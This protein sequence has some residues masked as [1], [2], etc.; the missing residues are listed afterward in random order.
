MPDMPESPKLL[1]PPQSLISGVVK[2]A[3]VSLDIGKMSAQAVISSRAVDREFEIVEPEAFSLINYRK[4]PVVFFN[5]QQLP[6]P[7]GTSESPEKSLSVMVEADRVLATCYFSQVLPE[8]ELIY[9]LVEEKTIRATSIGFMSLE[10]VRLSDE[11]SQKLGAK[12]PIY[13]HKKIDLTE[14]SWV[15]VGCNQEA[16][17][18]HLANGRIGSKQLT[19]A[20][21]KTLEP[22]RLESPAMV[23]VP[24]D[25][26]K[27]PR[28][29]SQSIQ[30]QS[31]SNPPQP[32][33]D[34]AMPQK[35][36][37]PTTTKSA[38]A[39]PPGATAMQTLYALTRSC[40][41]KVDELMPLNERQE[42]IEELRSFRKLN[43]E[44][45]NGLIER[46]ANLY[47]DI[48][49]EMELIPDDDDKDDDSDSDDD[50]ADK[51]D[52]ADDGDKSG[53]SDDD[54]D[55]KSDDSDDDA[56]SDDSDDDEKAIQLLDAITAKI[57][58]SAAKLS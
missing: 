23:V 2:D 30:S 22:Y 1:L 20:L 40:L 54:A 12:W 14:W 7:V 48:E 33:S 52:D 18:R 8:A 35:P 51:S 45:A 56:K 21:I 19:P 9:R 27:F 50:D 38:D 15:G 4:N 41:A 5:H 42:I 55:D 47:P 34:I 17:S 29:K 25:V 44:Y 37:T 31:V 57:L 11:E 3:V 49:F 10:S 6:F 32:A 16:I 28:R 39:V 53:D 24:A 43:R 58:G 26:G 13:V 46:S 36:K